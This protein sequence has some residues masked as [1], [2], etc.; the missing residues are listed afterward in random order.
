MDLHKV[1]IHPSTGIMGVLALILLSGVARFGLSLEWLIVSLSGAVTF[2]IGSLLSKSIEDN[3]IYTLIISEV[4]VFVVIFFSFYR[5]AGYL[6]LL[7]SSTWLSVANISSLLIQLKEMRSPVYSLFTFLVGSIFVIYSYLTVPSVSELRSSSTTPLGGAFGMLLIFIS[8]PSIFSW[9]LELN[10]KVLSASLSLFSVILMLLHGF[11]AD[12]ILIILSTFLLLSKRNKK[13]SYL[14]LISIFFLYVGIDAIRTELKISILERPFFRLGTTY[15]YSKEL[16]SSFLK[17]LPVEPFWLTSVPL[18]P[19]QAIGRGIF[20]KDFGITPTIF[21]GMLMDLGF[22][23]MLLLSA[24]LGLVSGYSHRKFL[25]GR[26]VF[27]YSLIWPLLIT[28]TEVGMT[29][30]DLALVFG[31]IVFSLILNF[32]NRSRM[33]RSG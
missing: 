23:G 14:V 25:E 24:L 13:L 17:L 16:A 26:D 8:Y 33:S 20:G 9:L 5:I 21:V 19:S 11:R 27:S 7:I 10:K 12:A 31:S 22:L 30:L 1:L 2:T 18:H 15:Y 28:R 4:I 32:F 6:S 3:P 29:Q